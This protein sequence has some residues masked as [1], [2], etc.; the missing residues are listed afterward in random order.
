MTIAE[1]CSQAVE[2]LGSVNNAAEKLSISASLLN[3]I[4]RL[5]KLDSRVQEMVRRG[6]ILFDTAQRLNAIQPSER[7]YEVAKLLLDTSNKKQREIIQHALRFPQSDLI[8]YRKR[9]TGEKVR[10]ERIRVVIIPMQEQLYR[11]LEEVSNQLNKPTEKIIPE[12]IS[13]WL[14]R[15]HEG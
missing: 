8:D 9:V 11:S 4:I 3:S 2:A 14:E 13:D 10:R 12:I 6:D 15:R 1:K 5:E 7:Q